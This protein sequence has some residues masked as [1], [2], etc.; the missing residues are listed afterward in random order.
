MNLLSPDEQ[1]IATQRGTPFIKT[2]VLLRQELGRRLNCTPESLII[3]TSKHGK[4]YLPNNALHFNISHSGDVLC[5]A[6]H[7]AP[8]G[9][10]VQQHRPQTPTTRLAGKIMCPEQL[11]AWQKRGCTADEFFICWCV[12]E[13]LVKQ[14]GTT[15]WQAHMHPFLYH[16]SGIEP[17]FAHAPS[18]HLFSPAPG[19]CGA[20]AFSPIPPSHSPQNA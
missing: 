7:Q 17:L 15:I 16:P 3:H 13:A 12:A 9:V 1:R 11:D 10:D 6:F 18:L 5:L 19:Y 2:R 14:A 4:P 8:V 20:I